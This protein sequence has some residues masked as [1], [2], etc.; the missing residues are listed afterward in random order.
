MQKKRIRDKRR[1]R[2]CFVCEVVILPHDKKFH[3]P[4]D[5]PIYANLPIHRTCND[6]RKIEEIFNNDEKAR[7]VIENYG[8]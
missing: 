1:K 3:I 7:K 6:P 8:K 2:I 5:R 4:L